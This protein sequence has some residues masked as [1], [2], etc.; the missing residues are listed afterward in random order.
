MHGLSE[1][2]KKKGK[3]ND[4]PPPLRSSAPP[5]THY[6]LCENINN[7]MSYV[8]GEIINDYFIRKSD[9]TACN[10][11]C[12]SESF[13]FLVYLKLKVSWAGTPNDQHGHQTNGTFML[14]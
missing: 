10:N 6:H 7:G 8:E 5:L 14:V 9:V 12:C 3:S 2:P 4:P 11:E 1:I 13:Y